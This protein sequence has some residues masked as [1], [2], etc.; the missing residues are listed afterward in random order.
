MRFTDVAN[1]SE[2]SR[3]T[4]HRILSILTTEQLV[5]FDESSQ[6]YWLGPKP[7]IWAKQA[8]YGADLTELAAEEMA[9]LNM[10][11][12]EHV[13]LAIMDGD[14]ILFVKTVDSHTPLRSAARVGEHCP[15]HCTAVGKCIAAYMPVRRQQELIKRIDFEQYSP[16]TILDAE[17]FEAELEQIRKEG[18]AVNNCEEIMSVHGIAAPI[19]GPDGN[20]SASICIWCPVSRTPREKLLGW[21]TLLVESAQKISARLGYEEG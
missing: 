20:V 14:S 5:D 15:V 9:R 2:F 17:T 6:T 3:S 12:D 7:R 10:T 13:A 4:T 18:F 8:F 1:K 21:K 19:F 16:N 11:T